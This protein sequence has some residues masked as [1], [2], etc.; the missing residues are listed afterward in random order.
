[1]CTGI[2]LV[3]YPPQ[4]HPVPTHKYYCYGPYPHSLNEKIGHILLAGKFSFWNIFEKIDE[5]SMACLVLSGSLFNTV[6][7][8]MQRSV[9]H[10]TLFLQKG[11]ERDEERSCLEGT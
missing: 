11:F 4:P 7:P 10:M 6:G 5:R 3:Y 1:M 8:C 9:G 2:V